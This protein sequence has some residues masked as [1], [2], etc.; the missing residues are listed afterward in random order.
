MQIPPMAAVG[1]TG[2]YAAIF[3]LLL[4]ALSINVIR[5]RY[6]DRVSLGDGGKERLTRA[7]R[8]QGNF[9]EYV[10]MALLLM[11]LLELNGAGAQV[12]HG[13]GIALLAGRLA[14]AYSLVAD[15]LRIRQ[16][17]MLLTFGT[18]LAGAG[19]LLARVL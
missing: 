13:L 3:A 14:H 1:V 19:L 10:P 8:V 5:L 11:L 18:L 15:I 7:I 16:I 4:V 6:A 17:G 2:L 9:C 12:L